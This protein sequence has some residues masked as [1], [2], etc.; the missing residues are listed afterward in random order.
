[1]R[2]AVV[3][4]AR[5]ERRYLSSLIGR[6]SNDIQTVI[7]V[8]DGST[9]ATQRDL[10]TIGDARLIVLR[11]RVNLG[12]GAALRTGC[13]AA[14][15]LGAEVIILMD[16]DGQHEPEN[17]SRFLHTLDQENVDMVFGYR[18]I[19]KDMP[20]MMMIGNKFLSIA[21]NLIFGVYLLDTQS[22]F[23]AFRAS[24]YPKIQW[25]SR[26]YSVETEMIA[27]AAK[28]RITFREIEIKT[29]YHDKHKGTTPFDGI[30][31]FFD[32]LRWKLV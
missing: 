13:D 21:A 7:V 9:D 14:I 25:K 31:I 17:T 10:E 2:T 29:I 20:L 30:K 4:P 8:D 5:N 22:G 18:K 3:I 19:G 32:M 6:I 27:R 15:T 12:K 28:Y 26:G 23:R 16:A 11:H 1:M 24:I